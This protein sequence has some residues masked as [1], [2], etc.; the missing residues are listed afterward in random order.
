MTKHTLQ[1]N[2]QIQ[3]AQIIRWVGHVVRMDREMRVKRITECR[4]IALRRIGKRRLRW[5]G[6]M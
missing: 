1:S 2:I 4:I 3:L 5:E 6:D